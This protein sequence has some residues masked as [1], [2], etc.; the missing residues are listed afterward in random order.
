MS[1]P[2]VIEIPDGVTTGREIVLSK[3]SRVQ[4]FNAN[5]EGSYV[6]RC[7]LPVGA[8]ITMG[9]SNVPSVVHR[10]RKRAQM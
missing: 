4:I 9:L 6:I 10:S 7:I 8:E 5:P 1:S 2:Y 3:G